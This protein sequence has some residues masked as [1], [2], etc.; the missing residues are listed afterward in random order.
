MSGSSHVVAPFDQTWDSMGV[1]RMPL[2]PTAEQLSANQASASVGGA[3]WLGVLSP[4]GRG[5]SNTWA[6]VGVGLAPEKW[7][8]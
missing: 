1:R 6:A 8:A 4:E 7:V 2:S 5:A 3:M